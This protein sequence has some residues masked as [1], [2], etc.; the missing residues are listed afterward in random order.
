MSITLRSA[1]EDGANRLIEAGVETGRREAVWLLSHLLGID[2]ALMLARWE[3]NLPLNVWQAY[4]DL[5]SRRV[6][7]EPLQY[8]LGSTTFCG[9]TIEVNPSVLIPRPETEELVG[10]ALELLPETTTCSVVD[11]GTGSGC[12]ALAIKSQRPLA[13]VFGY[14]IETKALKTAISNAKRLNL[15][16]T[17]AQ[18]DMLDPSLLAV[19]KES[20]DLIVSNPPYV[21]T[22]ESEDLQPEVVQYEP[23]AALF[24]AGDPLSYYAAI[25]T[26]GRK[27]LKPDG[28]LLLESHADRAED[29][30]AL[31]TALGYD[32]VSIRQDLAGLSRMVAARV[33]K[34]DT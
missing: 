2:P 9:L 3:D 17:F 21:C 14:E 8:I 26:F 28:T 13:D 10:W 24:S 23:H 22:D 5:I 31:L 27:R 20:A 18:A 29:V 15:D 16:V 33:S 34:Q 30:A 19:H 1:R 32:G 7:R 25:G 4:Q 12:I 11:L 6:R